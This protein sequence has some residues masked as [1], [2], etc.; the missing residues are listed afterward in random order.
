MMDPSAM[1]LSTQSIVRSDCSTF[2]QRRG[3]DEVRVEIT[4]APFDDPQKYIALSYVWGSEEDPQNI[5]VNGGSFKVT[6]NL[7]QALQHLR[8]MQG[9]DAGLPFW[10]DAICINQSDNVEKS[11]QVRLMTEIY[12]RACKVLVWLGPP[13]DDSELALAKMKA[14]EAQM[15]IGMIGW[16]KSVKENKLELVGA[17]SKGARGSWSRSRFY[18]NQCYRAS[19][20]IQQAEQH[21]WEAI[22]KFLENPWWSRAWIVQEVT[23]PTSRATPVGNVEL[24]LARNLETVHLR[25]TVKYLAFLI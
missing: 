21:E 17:T 3:G 19:S 5:A 1:I 13:D 16:D 12:S 4:H 2:T 18:L 14:V 6:K 15:F 10:I 11:R 9:P 22:L 25:S 7:F 20:Y 8:H 23:S 24:I